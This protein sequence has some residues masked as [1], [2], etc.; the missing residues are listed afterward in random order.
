MKKKL[1]A[2]LV[3][4][5]VLAGSV[6]VAFTKEP[7]DPVNK[8]RN[9]VAIKGYDPVAYF[10]DGRPTK[11]SSEYSAQWAG[12]TYLFANKDHRDAFTAAPE[13]YAPQ[14]GG[15]CAWA[16]SNS[17]T[18]D[19]DPAAWKII[20]GKLYLNYNK[21]VQSKWEPESAKRIA[22]ADK[23]WPGLHK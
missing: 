5:F 22:A 9:G 23:N 4:S 6:T 21:S 16:V 18:A 2:A 19:A 15:Y 13:K 17:Y 20:D 14:Y 11:G 7:V 8:D 1:I 10:E 12:A 3:T